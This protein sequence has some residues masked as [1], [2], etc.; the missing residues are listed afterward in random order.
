MTLAALAVAVDAAADAPLDGALD[1]IRP[2]L[3]DIGWF[4]AWMTQQA[5]SY[6]HLTLPTKA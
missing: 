5:V 4:Q 2:F 1:H 3:A 6:T